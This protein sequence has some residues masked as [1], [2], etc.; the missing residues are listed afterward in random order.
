MKI[1][2]VAALGLAILFAACSS[3]WEDTSP[4]ELIEI[5]LDLHEVDVSDEDRVITVSTRVTDDLS[6]VKEVNLRFT[7]L[8]SGQETG[9]SLRPE[10]LEGLITDGEYVGLLKFPRFSKAGMWRLEQVTLVD[11]IGNRK[12]YDQQELALLGLSASIEVT[13]TEEDL[14]APELV[15]LSIESTYYP[16]KPDPYTNIEF[17]AWATDDLSGVKSVRI[18]LESPKHREKGRDPWDFL[19]T[20]ETE[21]IFQSGT[22]WK[23]RRE[24]EGTGRIIKVEIDDNVGN[25]REYHSD[26]LTSLGLDATFELN[27]TLGA[28]AVPPKLAVLTMDP[29]K[30]DTSRGVGDISVRI[31]STDDALWS[32]AYLEFES[33]TGSQTA[34]IRLWDGF[35]RLLS[36]DQGIL[37]LPRFSEAGTW[38]VAELSLYGNEGAKTYDIEELTDLGMPTSFEVT[39]SGVDPWDI[40]SDVEAPEVV[41]VTLGRFHGFFPVR[42]GY[43]LDWEMASELIVTVEAIDNLSG[44]ESVYVDLVDPETGRE[45]RLL[46]RGPVGGSIVNGYYTGTMFTPDPIA[47]SSLADHLVGVEI[48]DYAGNVRTYGL[49]ELGPLTS[50]VFD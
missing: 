30:V 41:E 1:L 27:G 35:G 23:E 38:R 13:T 11:N 31:R 32:S 7:S 19:L 36:R 6:G 22:S 46:V 26:E 21:G 17:T 29:L 2:G 42:G 33:P 5:S 47:I 37:R 39:A 40:S 44:V 10:F 14:T 48:S 43:L 28:D 49:D 34:E 15:D 4:P 16:D 8:T 50:I 12:E 25:R 3:E 9:T 45:G 20:F 18:Y 24:I